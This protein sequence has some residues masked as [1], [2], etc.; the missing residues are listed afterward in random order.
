MAYNYYKA[1]FW[2]QTVNRA[3]SEG[4]DVGRS[5]GYVIRC[6]PVPPAHTQE[7]FAWCSTKSVATR[8]LVGYE[9]SK[10]K[11]YWGC[12]CGS[13]NQARECCGIPAL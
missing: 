8:T 10:R 2:I 6:R 4:I 11:G 9:D 1:K 3:K 7:I 12:P 13:D 5:W